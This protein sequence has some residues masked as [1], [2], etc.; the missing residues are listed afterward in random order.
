MIKKSYKIMIV[1]RFIRTFCGFGVEKSLL[2]RNVF[3]NYIVFILELI[4]GFMS[5]ANIK[6]R[7]PVLYKNG[8]N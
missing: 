1:P 5:I 4:L 6:R 2:P 7:K 3:S 8:E